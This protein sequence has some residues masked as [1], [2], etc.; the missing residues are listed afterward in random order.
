MTFWQSDRLLAL[1][2]AL[3]VF[4]GGAFLY[5]A[6]LKLREPWMLFAM[7]VD[8]YQLLPQWA[9]IFVA[10]TLPWAELLLG[11][12]LLIG[13]RWIRFTSAAVSALLAG[14]LAMM[15]HSYLKGMQINCGCFGSGEPISPRTLARDSGLLAAALVLTI[16]SFRG[17]AAASPPPP[18][19]NEPHRGQ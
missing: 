19:D 4:L 14:F 15:V 9:V 2:L 8:A 10:R 18:P 3:R 11:L 16:I 7:A 6:W 17:R 12:L 1:R 5:A 13:G